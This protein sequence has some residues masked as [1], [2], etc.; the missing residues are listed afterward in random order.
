MLE[1][2]PP[3]VWPTVVMHDLKLICLGQNDC[4]CTCS[5][6]ELDHDV[7][8][9]LFQQSNDVSGTLKKDSQNA[10][11]ALRCDGGMSHLCGSKAFTESDCR[12]DCNCSDGEVQCEFDKGC[13]D[14]L[15]DACEGFRNNAVM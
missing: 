2:Q 14:Q 6:D 7:Q 5:P 15:S 11:D 4:E 8:H 9:A 13:Q 12:K 10:S 1:K 3:F